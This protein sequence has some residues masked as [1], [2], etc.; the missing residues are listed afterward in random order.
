[1][2][3]ILCCFNKKQVEGSKIL[4]MRLQEGHDSSWGA[5]QLHCCFCWPYSGLIT[6]RIAR[7]TVYSSL[8]N[9]EVSCAVL[10]SWWRIQSRLLLVSRGTHLT[11]YCLE[12]DVSSGNLLQPGGLS[13]KVNDD[14]KQYIWCNMCWIA[15]F[16]LRWSCPDCQWEVWNPVWVAGTFA[17]WNVLS[18]DVRRSTGCRKAEANY[19]V[20]CLYLCVILCTCYQNII[21]TTGHILLKLAESNYWMYVNLQLTTKKK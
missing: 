11:F 6:C 15:E 1:M 5:V 2:E 20:F 14:F 10:H 7:N 19:F 16:V 13:N 18:A 3:L 21:W 17:E 4:A 12:Q 9:L 8:F